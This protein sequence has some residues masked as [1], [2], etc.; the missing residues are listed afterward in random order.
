MQKRAQGTVTVA[1]LAAA[2]ALCAAPAFAGDRE[3]GEDNGDGF[4]VGA[5]IGDFNANLDS[6]N[7]VDDIK[8]DFDNQ[9]ADRVSAGWRF[10]R[11]FAVQLDYTDFGES[12]AAPNQLGIRAGSTGWT[13]AVVGTLPLGPVELF[14]KAG[15]LYYNVD[16]NSDSN[17]LQG[18]ES[19]SGHDSLYGAG[20]GFTVLK[21]LNLSAEYERVHMSQFSDADAV[22]LNASWRF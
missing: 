8:L 12:N 22:W 20:I 7:D 21:R 13:P 3:L 17:N 2:L 4:F 15:I 1:S 18:F 5:S 10:N 16:F 9:D 19:D 6:P 11:F 14:A